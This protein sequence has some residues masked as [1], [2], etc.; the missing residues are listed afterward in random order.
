MSAAATVYA[1]FQ[2]YLPTLP[3]TVVGTVLAA[4]GAFGAYQA[5]KTRRREDEADDEDRRSG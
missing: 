3:K 4:A 1:T 5:W 2:E